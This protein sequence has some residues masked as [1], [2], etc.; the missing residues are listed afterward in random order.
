MNL[1]VAVR[2][3]DSFISEL[4]CSRA[5][6]SYGILKLTDRAQTTFKWDFCVSRWEKQWISLTSTFKKKNCARKEV[7]GWRLCKLAFKMIGKGAVACKPTGGMSIGLIWNCSISV[8]SVAVE[9][10]LPKYVDCLG[11]GAS[12]ST[13]Q[14]WKP[15]M[16]RY[17]IRIQIIRGI[18]SSVK[19]L[20]PK[21]KV[22]RP[23]LRKW[24]QHC[25]FDETYMVC[26]TSHMII[27]LILLPGLNLS[28][29][30]VADSGICKLEPALDRK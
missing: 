24:S 25:F 13:K 14:Q 1:G 15:V 5:S 18:M 23:S 21:T 11:S 22:F 29:G 19:T 4:W 10:P 9:F 6:L 2:S 16:F 8:R 7:S 17:S 12:C 20:L 27:F 30:N 3:K 26:V 28:W